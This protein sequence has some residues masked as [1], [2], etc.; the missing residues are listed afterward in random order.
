MS[1]NL[2]LPAYEVCVV[3][4]LAAAHHPAQSLQLGSVGT[5]GHS[6][7]G[8][9]CSHNWTLPHGVTQTCACIPLS[10]WDLCL[11]GLEQEAVTTPNDPGS[12]SPGDRMG[13]G[14]T[15]DALCP[16]T[17]VREPSSFL[18]C[19]CPGLVGFCEIRWCGGQ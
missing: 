7:G 3:G 1:L 8:W 9:T 2:P 17:N 4:K 6:D 15:R 14:E 11:V 16:H 19:L 13:Q 12:Y 10:G 18:G 5:P